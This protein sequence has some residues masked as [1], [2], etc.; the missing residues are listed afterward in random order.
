MDWKLIVQCSVFGIIMASLSLRGFTQKLEPFLWLLLGIFTA[1]VVSKNVTQQV[2][3][4]G[5][6]IGLLWGLLNGVLQATFFDTYLQ[7][8]PQLQTSFQKTTIKAQYF[9]LMTSPIIGLMVGLVLGG[10]SLL[11][12]KILWNF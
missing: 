3:L 12:K 8:N 7:H 2:F 4:H 9:V 1:L 6:C 11:A 5:F 10:L